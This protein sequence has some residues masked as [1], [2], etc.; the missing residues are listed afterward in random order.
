MQDVYQNV[1]NYIQEEE[2]KILIVFDDMIAD[3]TKTKKINAIVIELFTR[4]RKLNISVTF[5]T[6]SILKYQKKLD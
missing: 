6:Q 1:E 3:M 4:C 5:I 2:N